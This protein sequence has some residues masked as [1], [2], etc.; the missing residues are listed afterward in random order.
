MSTAIHTPLP[1]AENVE[2]VPV[3]EPKDIERTLEIIR[4]TLKRHFETA[5]RYRR[6]VHVKAHGCA[7]GDF[8]IQPDLPP[9]LSQGLFAI[10]ARHPAFVRFSNSAP[11]VQPD[12]V[13]DGRGMAMRIGNVPGKKLETAGSAGTSQDFIMVNSS[14]FLARNV[15]D[16]LSL[17]EARL[18]AN[19]HPA[20]TMADWIFHHW[21][22]LGWRWG[23][24]GAVFKVAAQI[25]SHP[26]S[27]TYYSMAPIRFGR[28][29]A[30][31]RIRPRQTT[32]ISATDAAAFLCTRD[33]MARLLENTLRQQS[34]MFD[35]Q[36]QLRTSEE[37]MPVEDATVEWPEAASPY[38][39]VAVLVLPRQDLEENDCER[40]SFSV[41]NG[42]ADHRPLGGINRVR[43]LAYALSAAARQP[44]ASLD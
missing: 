6:D 31:Y 3:D 44:H 10:P 21:N 2:S 39:T 43:R 4:G 27:Y 36:V 34:L 42:L 8:V 24:I 32:L 17:E 29:V 22:P 38:R 14:T 9:E 41:W 15:K 7:I 33:P 25:P 40:R 37:S 5:G 18:A 11:L 1:Y 30:K 20:R 16:Y 23:Q 26:A 13:P 28:Y 35:F 19:Y 12:V